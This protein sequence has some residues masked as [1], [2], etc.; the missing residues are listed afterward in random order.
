MKEQFSTVEIAGRNVRY[1]EFKPQDASMRLLVVQ[2]H[3]DDNTMAQGVDYA[4]S[5]RGA[6]LVIATITDGGKGVVYPARSSDEVV[7]QRYHEDRSLAEF[8]KSDSHYSAMLPY[9]GRLSKHKK[10]AQQV[11]GSIIEEV[12]PD[13]ILVPNPRDPHSDHAVGYEII[14]AVTTLPLYPMDALLGHDKFGN[15]IEP[16]HYIPLSRDEQQ[17]HSIG[18]TLFHIGQTQNR[19]PEEHIVINN[20]LKMPEIRGTE[21]RVRYGRR[22]VQYAGSLVYDANKHYGQDPIADVFGKDIFVRKQ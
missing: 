13:A 5:N 22:D 1:T 10:D 7:E 15:R 11:M 3:P 8:L 19:K 12:K 6:S 2:I 4:A 14:S 17:R 16:T 18:F 20:V 9:D 21:M